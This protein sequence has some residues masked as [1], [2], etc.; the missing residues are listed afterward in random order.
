[1]ART[2]VAKVN[3][4]AL[5]REESIHRLTQAA[6]RL[7]VD[8]GYQACTLQEIA[9]AAG[10]TKGAIFFY[11]ES[12]ENLL[13]RLVDIAETDMVDPLI[14]FLDELDQPAPEKIASFFRFTSKQGIERP[15][16][17]L[18]LIKMSIESRS[19]TEIVDRRIAEIYQRIYETLE[20]I[21]HQGKARGELPSDLP[22]KEFA[23]LVVATHDGMM[24]EWH[25]RGGKIDGRVFVRTV[26]QTFLRGILVKAA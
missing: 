14:K 21:T 11:F 24:L 16:E 20:R 17:L 8:K 23:M 4:K 7:I 12:K 3:K 22:T 9:D 6:F 13:L 1:M 15:H 2:T 19:G 25:R 10:L 5:L 18:C 26:W